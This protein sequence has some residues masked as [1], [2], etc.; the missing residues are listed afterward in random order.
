MGLRKNILDRKGTINLRVSDIFNTQNFRM[1][2]YGDNFTID[3]ER[4]RNSRMVFIGFTYRINE[5]NNRRNQR[6]RES[7]DNGSQDFD[8]FDM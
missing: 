8:E 7:M 4:K 1:Y 2:N 6:S 5:Y 3:M